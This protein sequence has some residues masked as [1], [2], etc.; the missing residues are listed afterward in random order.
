V[1]YAYYDPQSFLV[2]RYEIAGHRKNKNK[3]VDLGVSVS[4]YRNTNGILF[5]YAFKTEALLTNP[6]ALARGLPLVFAFHDIKKDWTT[7]T[8]QSIEINPDMDENSFQMPGSEA[9]A[10]AKR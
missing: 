10:S 5:P 1:R 8:V 3:E 9:A 4:D 2:V 6:F 7:S